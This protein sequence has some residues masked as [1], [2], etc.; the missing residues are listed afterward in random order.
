MTRDAIETAITTRALVDGGEG[1]DYDVGRIMHIID[2][3]TV[4]VAWRSGVRT[5]CPVDLLSLV[6]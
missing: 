3:E 2:A 1:E 6:D 4:M 5:P